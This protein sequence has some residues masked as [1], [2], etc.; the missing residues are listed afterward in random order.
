MKP[1]TH[2]RGIALLEVLGALAVGAILI[3]SLASAMDTS[4][5]DV[6]G[7][8][9]AY[10][11][12]QVTAAGQKYIAANAATLP[13][14]TA[15]VAVGV[16]EL[17]A[18]KFLSGSTAAKNVY[19][20]TPCVLIRQPDPV[21]KP[22]Q[23][24]ALVATSGGDAIPDRALAMIAANAGPGG[25]YIAS[26][27][28]ATAKGATWSSDTTFFRT[29]ACAGAS[30]LTGGAADAGHLAS[31]LFYG[32]PGQQ[33]DFLYR[34]AVPGHPELNR[35][36][37]P[38][39]MAA[40]ALVTIGAAC[41]EPG[42]AID[43]AT[44]GLAVCGAAG[45]WTLPS[46]W[47]EPVEQYASLPA[48]GNV[49]G[50]VHMV[51]NLARAFT[52]DGASWV[53]LAVDQNGNLNVPAMLTAADAHVTSNIVADGTIHAAGDM[54]TAANMTADGTIHATGAIST[55]ATVAAT[56]DVTAG[57]TVITSGLEV[58]RWASTPAIT[59]GINTFVPGQACHYLAYDPADGLTTIRYPV[60]TVVMNA[61]YVPLIC[62]LD[63]TMRFA[64]G[65]YIQ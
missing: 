52:W 11:Q 31:N 19:G 64:N 21:G 28:P 9:A 51:M 36:T 4:L 53:A 33:A 13:A 24:D 57:R 16:P 15:L 22:G 20:Q 7:Q 63:H 39:R 59:I 35:M 55:D 58:D 56:L 27:Q 30:A 40:T 41:P 8:Q 10:Y 6:K 61:N 54:T 34:D 12:S 62:G 14:S 5:E 48:A 26:T 2:Q 17:I 3:V 23:F 50:D 65:T 60:G 49:R 18:G 44:R 37:T 1:L 46:Q 38:I 32:G 42:I 25:G 45:V 43:A 47:K 29:A